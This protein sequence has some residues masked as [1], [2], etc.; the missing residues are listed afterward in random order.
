[1]MKT[2]A[3]SLRHM[4]LPERVWRHLAFEGSFKASLPDGA[5][6]ILWHGGHRVENEIFWKGIFGQWEKTS[7]RLW[8]N[9]VRNSRCIVDVGANTGVYSLLAAAANLE[10]TILSIEPLPAAIAQLRRNIA[11]NDALVL[12]FE[13]VLSDQNSEMTLHLAPSAFQYSA[14]L[15]PEFSPELTETRTVRASTFDRLVE[16]FDLPAPDLVKIDVEGHEPAV[17][18][19]MEKTLGSSAPDLLIEVL[20]DRA[21]DSVM[22]ELSPLGYRHQWIDE[23]VGLVDELPPDP[24]SR[25]IWLTV[26]H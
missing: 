21:L 17:L 20:D 7:L 1:M 4:P 25:N 22:D 16:E 2:L 18:S 3:A 9:K 19:G 6:I 15:H 26:S 24:H 23:A 11:L 5:Q 14:S 13:G 8:Y 12:V 10:A